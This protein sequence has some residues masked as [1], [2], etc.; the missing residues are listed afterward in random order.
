MVAPCLNDRNNDE[1]DAEAGSAK[2]DGGLW[3]DFMRCVVDELC[4]DKTEGFHSLL[5]EVC[6]YAE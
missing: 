2:D 6:V 4:R 1:D 3:Q 5:Q